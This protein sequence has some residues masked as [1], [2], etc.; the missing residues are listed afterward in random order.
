MNTDKRLAKIEELSEEL[1][2]ANRSFLHHHGW[3]YTCDVPSSIWL[4]EKKLEDGRTI[5]VSE[6]TAI[7][8]QEYLINT[9]E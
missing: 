2:A 9:S 5:L 7:G 8:I 3:N 4:W 6:G 1:A